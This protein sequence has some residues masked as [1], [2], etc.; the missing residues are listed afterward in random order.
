MH[1]FSVLPTA[2][3]E[4]Q[5]KLAQRILFLFIIMLIVLVV[6]PWLRSEEITNVDPS[7][8]FTLVIMLP[9]LAFTFYNALKKQ[10]AML[11]SYKLTIPDESITREMINVPVLVI[12]RQD[13]REITK[14]VDGT[15]SVIGDSKLNAIGVPSRIEKKEELEILLSSIKPMTVKTSANWYQR[16]PFVIVTAVVALMFSVFYLENKFLSSVTGVAF[17]GVM[18]YCLIVIQK[19]KNVDTRTKRLSYF[20]IIP[21]LSVIGSLIMK[22]IN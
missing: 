21:L 2:H 8:V 20:V 9:I 17:V 3:K 12:H 16:Y 1:Q 11:A 6:V 14:N 19:S 15:I 18:I 22:W 7:T 13:I 10:K 5:R 4:L